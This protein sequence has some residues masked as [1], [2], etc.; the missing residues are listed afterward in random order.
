LEV[1][2]PSNWDMPN[3]GRIIFENLNDLIIIIDKNF[4]IIYFN[5]NSLLNS[6]SHSKSDILE[7]NIFNNIHDKDID[8]LKESLK[9]CKNNK[10]FSL[11]LKMKGVYNQFIT[12][13]I[14]GGL[15]QKIKNSEITF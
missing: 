10:F 13:E 9:Q 5:D 6:L 8:L 2:I 15:I 1:E 11:K 3:E 12:Y 4:N 7:R 14:K